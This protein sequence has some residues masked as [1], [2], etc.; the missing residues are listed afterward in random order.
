MKALEINK[1]C[2]PRDTQDVFKTLY[3]LNDI[4]SMENI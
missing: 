2:F 3:D 4:E 1:G